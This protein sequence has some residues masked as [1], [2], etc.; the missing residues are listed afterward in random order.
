MGTSMTMKLSNGKALKEIKMVDRLLKYKTS[1]V[2]VPQGKLGQLVLNE[3]HDNSIIGHKK[4][5]P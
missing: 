3:K 1:W 2:Y 4:K 5:P